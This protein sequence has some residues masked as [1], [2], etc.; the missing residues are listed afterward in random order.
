MFKQDP[1]F[2]QTD[3]QKKIKKEKYVHLN[4]EYVKF[5]NWKCESRFGVKLRKRS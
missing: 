1:P 4:P 3:D 5:L 2:F